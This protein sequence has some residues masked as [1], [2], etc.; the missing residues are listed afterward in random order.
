MLVPFQSPFQPGAGTAPVQPLLAGA[1]AP[2]QRPRLRASRDITVQDLEAAIENY[3]ERWGQRDM[4]RL[5]EELEDCVY[6]CFETP[7]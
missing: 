3:L 2:M 1:G 5:K 6:I 4:W 7:R